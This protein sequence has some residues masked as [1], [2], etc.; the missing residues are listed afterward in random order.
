[1][2]L[3]KRLWRNREHNPRPHNRYWK[4]VEDGDEK[5]LYVWRA[6]LPKMGATE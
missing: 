6:Y 1:M 2:L 3:R 5:Y 4:M